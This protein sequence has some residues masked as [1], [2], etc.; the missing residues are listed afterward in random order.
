MCAAEASAPDPQP[1]RIDFRLEGEP[2]QAVAVILHLFRWRNALTRLA[3][4]GTEAAVVKH[5]CR[6]TCGGESARKRFQVHFLHGA[7]AMGHGDGGH[8]SVRRGA[9]RQ[10]EPCGGEGLA[11]LE[12]HITFFYRHGRAPQR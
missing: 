6:N 12:H 9:L 2:R 3:A 8:T 5:Q 11:A 4:A 1:V 10:E 7:E